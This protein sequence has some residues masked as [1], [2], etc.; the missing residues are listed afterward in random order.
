MPI[1]ALPE[2]TVRA[3]SSSQVLT[4]SASLVK[5]LVDNALDAQ[6]STIVVEISLNALDVIQVKDNGHGIAPD[7][8]SLVCQRYCTS[9]I[10]DLNDLSTIGGTSLGFRGE[11]L[12][13]AT[14]MGGSVI[15]TTR[16]EGEPVAAALTFDTGGKIT[17][18]ARVSH[19]VGTTV[20]VVDFL[21]HMPVRR[22]TA[23]KATAKIPSKVKAILQAYAL[24]RP[25]VRFS[26]KVL[27]AQNDKDHWLYAPKVGATVTDA[28][29]KVVSQQV[30][31]QCQWH[32]WTPS[33]ASPADSTPEN[34]FA[35][36]ENSNHGYILESLL[37][38]KDCGHYISVDSRPVT[39]SR[40]TLKQVL[41]LYKSYMQSLSSMWQ[42]GKLVE[43][44][45]FLNIV[46][47]P[48]SYDP[49]IE[50]AKDDVLFTN[51]EGLIRT[52]EEFL[53]TIYGKREYPLSEAPTRKVQRDRHYDFEQLLSSRS[54]TAPH[55]A[56]QR[57]KATQRDSISQK[58][59]GR[60]DLSM[61]EVPP[62]MDGD[63]HEEI[64]RSN[65]APTSSVAFSQSGSSINQNDIEA[66]VA[67]KHWKR[68]MYDADEESEF[69]VDP[70]GETDITALEEDNVVSR[71]VTNLNPWTIAKLNAPVRRA[72]P[73][74][75]LQSN[76][77]LR[78]TEQLLTPAK[79]LTD[80]ST[81]S[82]PS[83]GICHGTNIGMSTNSL[84]SPV[85]S[86]ASV[87]ASTGG[88][89]QQAEL[90]FSSNPRHNM[91]R[92]GIQTHTDSVQ[93]AERQ[94]QFS[95]TIPSGFVSARNLPTGTPLSEIPDITQRTRKQSHRGQQQ[96][97]IIH[98]PFVA[99][100]QNPQS[101]DPMP[102]PPRQFRSAR[103]DQQQLHRTVQSELLLSDL[104]SDETRLLDVRGPNPQPRKMHPDLAVTMEYE[105]RKHLAMQ[106]RK[107]QQRQL[108]LNSV[109]PG[110]RQPLVSSS[111][112][113]NSPHKNRYNAAIAALSRSALE[114]NDSRRHLARALAAEAATS[115]M[116]AR[117]EGQPLKRRRT[118]N[119]PFEKVPQNQEVHDLVHT[120]RTTQEH[121][122]NKV[123]ASAGW[124]DYIKS[125][126]MSRGI[127]CTRE[128][129]RMWQETLDMLLRQT[130][131][132][133]D[134]LQEQPRIEL[135]S[136]LR[137]R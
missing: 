24:A 32:S 59:R 123:T 81:Y 31:A 94:S 96:Q 128:E 45:L 107:A 18:Q 72:Q 70:A 97:G 99:P 21:K 122:V 10:R 131:Q 118:A 113:S 51:P 57:L 135:W 20:R 8:R 133:E 40:G 29:L 79:N 114:H 88:V 117:D 43:P 92:N 54:T 2:T 19:P 91:I 13:S 63:V 64:L 108:S 126:V 85:P 11:A 42:Q 87:T 115:P 36:S 82:S 77:S 41:S 137:G 109:P 75:T 26:F 38:R 80:R 93:P 73:A 95:S 17:N 60:I 35:A 124:D 104:Q 30:V 39:C 61:T 47:P 89:S 74:N 106:Q 111:T 33:A 66:Q 86:P 46:C 103:S 52:I 98:R 4:D 127:N 34:S 67:E 69:D 78:A 12:A 62:S 112:N 1:A 3:I 22:Q 55:E 119:M 7:D 37:P 76:S 83:A 121:M 105:E 65:A 116:A 84:P 28:A 125:G 129:A 15:L 132:R 53:T 71:D 101:V 90:P 136:V 44:F 58:P 120:V 110:A 6:A 14:E 68:G 102:G 25:S 23:L 50:P 27:K 134:E 49:N 48:G 5:E 100:S 130:F 9:K 16:I 56:Q